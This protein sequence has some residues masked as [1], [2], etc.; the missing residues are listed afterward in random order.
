[1]IPVK[2]VSAQGLT[3]LA[4]HPSPLD[5]GQ[6][7]PGP[8]PLEIEIG[9]GKGRYLRRRAI[10]EPGVRFLGFEIVSKYHSL[11]AN[12]IVRRQMGNL[13]VVRAEALYVVATSLPR[14]V[15]HR[16][17]VYFPDPWPK[18]KH[19]RRR[20]FDPA[21][22]DLVL[23]L[24]TAGGSL[25]FASDFVEYGEAVANLL[26]EHPSVDT[27]RLDAWP[28]GPRTNYESKYVRE[29][30]PIVRVEAQLVRPLELHPRVGDALASGWTQHERGEAHAEDLSRA[31]VPGP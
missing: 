21:T 9:F 20:L 22:V 5:L 18:S 13:A 14:G 24:L 25:S 27:V 4:H 10:A 11:L 16:V 26:E 30:R 6:L 7:L 12:R 2:I 28:E 8:G 15:A 23:G 29:G 1:M 3:S 31:V 19:H 17:H